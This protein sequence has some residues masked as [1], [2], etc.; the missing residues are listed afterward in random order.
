MAKQWIEVEKSAAATP[1]PRYECVWVR[2]KS[3]A[4]GAIYAS[5]VESPGAPPL[6]L[7]QSARR[8]ATC[9]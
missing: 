7:P 6:P 9:F 2:A 5:A 3:N 1:T 8:S 4:L